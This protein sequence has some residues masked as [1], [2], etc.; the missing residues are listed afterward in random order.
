MPIPAEVSWRD[1]DE[2]VALLCLHKPPLAITEVIEMLVR[3]YTWVFGTTAYSINSGLCEE[4]A[5][6]VAAIIPGAEALWGDEVAD[7][8]V[9]DLDTYAYHCIVRYDGRFYDSEHPQGVADF[10]DMTAYGTEKG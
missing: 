5:H 6:D 2:A 4:F 8:A 10:R 1:H 9:D 7:P 3:L